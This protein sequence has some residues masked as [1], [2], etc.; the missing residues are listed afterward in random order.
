MTVD[1]NNKYVSRL[2]NEWL[3]YKSIIIA[4]D[5]DDTI[6]PWKFSFESLQDTIECIKE[7]QYI[8]AYIII[9]TACMPDRYD[10]IKKYCSSVG[11]RVDSINTTP[12]H[13]IY[14]K[15]GK[16]YANIFL[17]DRAG[18]E[19][20]KEILRTAMYIVKGQNRLKQIQHVG[21]IA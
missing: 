18:L 19:E 6:S 12:D 10:D 2:A 7:A 21:E 3:M 1:T 9:N 14:G 16:V 17:D 8:G 11:I 5:Y 4:V 15:H 13:I 20:S